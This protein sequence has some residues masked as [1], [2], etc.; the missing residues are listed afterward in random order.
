MRAPVLFLVG[1]DSPPRELENARAVAAAL[2]DA[3]VLVMPGQQHAAMYTAPHVFS[4]AVLRF[5]ES[6]R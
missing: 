4:G 6:S 1:G 2:P 3:Q 5:L